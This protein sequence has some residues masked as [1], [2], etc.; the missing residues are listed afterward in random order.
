M[1]YLDTD[2]IPPYLIVGGF[3]VGAGIFTTICALCK[4]TEK[5]MQEQSDMID[6]REEE[7]IRKLW[8]F[9][10]FDMI[11]HACA[12][13]MDTIFQV[14]RVTLRLLMTIAIFSGNNLSKMR[15]SLDC[16][17]LLPLDTQYARVC[18]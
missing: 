15:L 16:V 11:I 9:F 3:V 2:I 10:I 18:A 17:I 6:E 4:L 8:L 14:S 13:N 7:P 5:L 1:P 12:A